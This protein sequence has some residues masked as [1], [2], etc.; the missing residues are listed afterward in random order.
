M[1][2]YITVFLIRYRIQNAGNIPHVS[3]TDFER[4][5]NNLKETK[6]NYVLEIVG[7]IFIK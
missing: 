5:K 4:N 3:S 2:K 7:L 6:N 1:T